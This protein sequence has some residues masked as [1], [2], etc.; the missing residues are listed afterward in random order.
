MVDAPVQAD[1]R[2]VLEISYAGTPEPVEA[3]THAQRLQPPPAGPSPTTGETWTMQ[4]PFGAFTWYAVNDQP[5]D[6][7][8]YDF[9]LT[10]PSPWSGVANGELLERTDDD[11]D[12]DHDRWHLAEPA[13]SYL[14][15]AGLR[16]LR[17]DRGRVGAAACRSPTGPRAADADAR[18]APC[19][20]PPTRWPGW[21]TC[22]AP[23]RSTPSA[24][25]SSTPQ[26]GMETQTMVTLG[27]SAYTTVAGGGAARAGAPVVRRPGDAQRLA[28]RV[29][30]RGHG[31]VPPGHVAGRAGRHLG[32]AADGRVGGVERTRA[33]GRGPAGRL[34]ARRLRRVRTST[35]ARR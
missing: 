15:T 23:T 20:S 17:D 2:Y 25:W 16:R 28:R 6:K 3:P 33:G 30:E 18:C 27:D 13:A 10:V 31:D 5:S 21:R 12:D 1:Q 8:L 26:S 35:T 32:R 29:D 14:V 19:R 7:A 22:W 4:E 11:G 9:T 34:R 24:S